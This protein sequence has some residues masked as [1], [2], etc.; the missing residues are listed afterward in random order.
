MTF[1]MI[2]KATVTKTVS[3][4]LFVFFML[5]LS[6]KSVTQS[7]EHTSNYRPASR[8]VDGYYDTISHTAQEP[9]VAQPWWMM[10]LCYEVTIAGVRMW[11]RRDCCGK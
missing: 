5:D 3:Y 1:Q 8:A 2:L 9:V 7:S 6:F 11:N 10:E 4:D